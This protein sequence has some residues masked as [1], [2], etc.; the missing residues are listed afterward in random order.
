MTIQTNTVSAGVYLTDSYI[1]ANYP[2]GDADVF[3]D[4]QGRMRTLASGRGWTIDEDTWFTYARRTFQQ[5]SIEYHVFG[6]YGDPS[7]GVRYRVA[8]RATK[9]IP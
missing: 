1:A 4:L 6:D 8:C 3:F 9:D 2:N 7:N 5:N